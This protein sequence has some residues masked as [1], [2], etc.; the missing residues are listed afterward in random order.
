MH[1]AAR[2]Y[3]QK[4]VAEHVGHTEGLTVL[5]FGS[6]NVNGTVRDHFYGADFCGVD[7]RDGPGVDIVCDAAEFDGLGQ[8]DVVVS[9]ET[10]EHAERPAEI[11][12]RAWDSLK[13]GGLLILTAAAPERAPHNGNGDPLQEGE[14]HYAGI[15]PL[16]LAGWLN[17]WKKEWDLIDL[18]HSPGDG[19]VYAVARK[20]G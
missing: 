19:D 8:Y 11:I 13:P 1:D 3:I 9:A 2:R 15:N 16:E 5:E 7:M 10:L 4:A 12:E 14:E 18:T 6:Y 20:R 17:A